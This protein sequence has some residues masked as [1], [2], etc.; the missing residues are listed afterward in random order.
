MG[1]G[2]GDPLSKG[3]RVLARESGRV[4]AKLGGTAGAVLLSLR[5]AEARAFCFAS[6]ISEKERDP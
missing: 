2:A 6:D 3:R 1:D 4:R 5:F